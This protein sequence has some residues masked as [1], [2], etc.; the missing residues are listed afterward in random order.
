MLTLRSSTTIWGAERTSA[1]RCASRESKPRDSTMWLVSTHTH[2]RFPPMATTAEAQSEIAKALAVGVQ[3]AALFYHA[4]AIAARMNDET[5]A[6]RY[7][8]KSLQVNPSSE[9][10]GRPAR[11]CKS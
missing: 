7:L 1:R 10:A 9:I 3:D 6:V 5:S 8:T 2:G 4:G 11:N